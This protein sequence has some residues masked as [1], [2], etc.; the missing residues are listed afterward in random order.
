M[1]RNKNVI[2]LALW[3][4][5]IKF[6]LWTSGKIS[7]GKVSLE[8]FVSHA[9]IASGFMYLMTVS[10][11]VPWI[12]CYLYSLHFAKVGSLTKH[13]LVWVTSVGL[14]TGP[15]TEGNGALSE[16]C[17]HYSKVCSSALGGTW[18]NVMI[19]VWE[20]LCH[21]NYILRNNITI[22]CSYKWRVTVLWIL[23]SRQI[24][25]MSELMFSY[26]SAC[27][28]MHVLWY[29]TSHWIHLLWCILILQV[30]YRGD[31]RSCCHRGGYFFL[32]R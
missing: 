7:A 2:P 19:H 22:S 8:G 31:M 16:K 5:I 23:Q 1:H 27:I 17:L 29:Q 13:M 20:C 21:F 32:W 26:F 3:S 15:T 24:Q 25:S 30:S 10:I 12:Y 18:L 11:V 14:T 6:L 4:F 28:H 9:M